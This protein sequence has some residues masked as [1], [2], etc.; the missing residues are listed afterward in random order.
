MIE[1]NLH[2]DAEPLRDSAI[3]NSIAVHAGNHRQDNN[4]DDGETDYFLPTNE[5]NENN[6]NEEQNLEVEEI[7]NL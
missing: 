6:E 4:G 7:E 3:E 5:N 1:G 2:R